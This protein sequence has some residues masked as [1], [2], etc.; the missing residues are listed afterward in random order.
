[1]LGVKALILVPTKELS[2]QASKNLKDLTS[3][4]SRDVRVVDVAQNSLDVVRYVMLNFFL[5]PS[6]F[7]S[8]FII[9]LV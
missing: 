7:L 4:C 2:Q 6:S 5:H 1:M 8:I 9:F 3:Y